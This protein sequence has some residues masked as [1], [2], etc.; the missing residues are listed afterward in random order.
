MPPQSLLAEAHAKL[1]A[2]EREALAFGFVSGLTPEQ[3]GELMGLEA[4]AVVELQVLG[5]LA[6]GDALWGTGT[7]EDVRQDPAALRRLSALARAAGAYAGW[8]W[9]RPAPALRRAV[10]EAAADA[11]DKRPCGEEA[12]VQR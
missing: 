12:L 2:P 10:L 1:P 3:V 8:D 7:L 4:D 9:E 5:L 6:L 11:L